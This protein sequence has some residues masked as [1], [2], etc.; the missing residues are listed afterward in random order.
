MWRHKIWVK[1]DLNQ[2]A[3]LKRENLGY[4]WVK[5]YFSVPYLRGEEGLDLGQQ[6]A[7]R[8]AAS[9]GKLA[10]EGAI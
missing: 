8:G 9:A 3:P 4:F 6:T 10:G 1:I 5:M 7:E 2:L